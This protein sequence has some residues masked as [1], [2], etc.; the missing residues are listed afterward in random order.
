MKDK[1]FILKLVVLA[2]IFVFSIYEIT[3][4]SIDLATYNIE[5]DKSMPSL[6]SGLVLFSLILAITISIIAYLVYKKYQKKYYVLK[7]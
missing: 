7:K 1:K 2:L 3:I 5:C 6:I 4:L